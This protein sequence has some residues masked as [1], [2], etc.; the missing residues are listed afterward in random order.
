MLQIP[1]VSLLW[2][3]FLAD[4]VGSLEVDNSDSGKMNHDPRK[5]LVHWHLVEIVSSGIATS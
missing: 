3:F 5:T 1:T 4:V 2:Y